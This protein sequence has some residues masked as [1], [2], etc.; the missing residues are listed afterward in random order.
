MRKSILGILALV[1]YLAVSAFF[2]FLCAARMDLPI[3][4]YYFGLNLA[5]GLVF[6]IVLARTNPDL[7]AERMKPGPGEQDRVFKI[8]S[9]ILT[10]LMMILAGLDVGQYHWTAPVA[11][12]VQIA[13][14]L[15]TLFGYG[16]ISWGVLTNRFFSSAVRLQ[17][18]RHQFVVDKGPYAFIRHP[19]YTGAIVYMGLTGLALGSWLASLVAGVPIFLLFLRRTILEDK[20]LRKGLPGYEEYAQRVR[21]RL[22]PGV[23]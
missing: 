16:F 8:A 10:L 11:P 19:G 1:A 3:A 13:A 20:M 9:S 5:L 12:G 17:P 22:L 15:A 7:I 23:W 14:L 18:D 21:F 4:W 2:Y 6:S